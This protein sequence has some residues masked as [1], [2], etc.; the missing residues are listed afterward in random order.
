[1]IRVRDEHDNVTRGGDV[2][3]GDGVAEDLTADDDAIVDAPTGE[4]RWVAEWRASG[5]PVPWAPGLTL[6]IFTLVVVASAI[7]VL[8]AGVADTPWLA[9]GLNL[10]VAGGIGPQLWLARGIPVLRFV[11]WGAAFGVLV[12]WLACFVVAF[13]AT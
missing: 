5:E 1:M 3:V 7:Y 8:T 11:A 9:L 12:G 2:A 6:S 13:P 4:W 10:V